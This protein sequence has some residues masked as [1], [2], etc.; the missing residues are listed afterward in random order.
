MRDQCHQDCGPVF[1]SVATYHSIVS[2]L[3]WRQGGGGGGGGVR[4]GLVRIRL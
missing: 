4:G 1:V 3:Q 2:L